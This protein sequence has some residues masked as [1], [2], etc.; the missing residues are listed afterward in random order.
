MRLAFAVLMTK[1]AE[2]E[3]LPSSKPPLSTQTKQMQEKKKK[4]KAQRYQIISAP[5]VTHWPRMAHCSPE[6]QAILNDLF[7]VDIKSL[8]RELLRF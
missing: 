2:H 7:N 5:E 3:P 8:S 1:H 6:Y 4:K